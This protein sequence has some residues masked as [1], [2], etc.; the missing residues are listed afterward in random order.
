[1][2]EEHRALIALS[3]VPG[4]GSG[5]IRALVARFGSA[6]G[7]LAS[8]RRALEQV[9]GIGAQTA[10]A[11]AAFN[12]F[13]RVDDQQ[14]RAERAGATL[15]TAWDPQYP[16]LL[17]QIYDA[18]A[19]LWVLGR[20]M[21]SDTRALAIVG[22]RRATEYGRETAYD[23]ASA[24]ARRGFTLVS[25]LA[26]GIDAAAHR[27][28]LEAGGRTLAV[29]GSGVDRVYPSRHQALAAAV[30][31]QGALL[32]EYA[33]GTPPDAPN[34]PRRNRLISGLCLGTLV[35]EAFERGGALITARMALE[36]N[37]EVFA[38][39]SPLH[40]RAGY[41]A[42]QLIQ[43]G[44][45]KL[46]LTV[47]DIL[48][49]LGEPAEASDPVAPVPPDLTAGE[50][51]IYDVLASGAQHIDSICRQARLDPSDALVHLLNLEF[52]GVVRQ[53]AGMQFYKTKGKSAGAAF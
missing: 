15:L 35:V 30:A 40:S 13:D 11:L 10:A 43:D 28:A 38:I 25:G 19:F 52:K 44:C 48:N 12:D 4:I 22:T 3:L 45:A 5:R 39:P 49:E 26:Y 21:P 33:L 34:F 36:H 37:R 24:L 27:G 2:V 7:V 16:P 18:P 31:R 23:F 29:L 8:S 17:R 42:N 9:A 46:V 20:V 6:V 47:E 51:Q 50:Q 41:G 32:S 14:I 53:M 1:M